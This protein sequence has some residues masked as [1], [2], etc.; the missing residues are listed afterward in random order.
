MSMRFLAAVSIWIGF[1]CVAGVLGQNEPGPLPELVPGSVRVATLNSSLFRPRSNELSLELEGGSSTH[2]KSIAAMVQRVRPD[3]L[4]INE[5]D[6]EPGGNNATKLNSLYFGIGQ[7]GEKAIVFPH[8]YSAEVNTGCPTGN[9]LDGDGKKDGPG[10]CFGYGTHPGQY[11][12]AVFSRFPIE[13]NQIRTFQKFI[14]NDMPMALLPFKPGSS[15]PYYAPDVWK[16]FRLS[17]KSHWDVP[18]QVGWGTLHFLVSHPTP[19]VFD[20]PEDRNGRR[21]HNEIRFFADYIDPSRA[22]YHYDDAGERGGLAAGALFVVAGDLNA[23]PLDGQSYAGAVDQLL[24]HPLVGHE[25]VPRSQGAEIAARNTAAANKDHRGD[26]ATDT[27]DFP[28][29]GVGNLRCDYCLPSRGLH[30]LASGV[31]WPNPGTAEA[32]WTTVTDHHL[33]WIDIVLPTPSR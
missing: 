1:G 22:T 33:V 29:D 11:G 4:L 5:L 31:F 15:E 28:D 32:E 25:P 26:P 27:G 10:D 20:G 9:D 18:I 2:A 13:E 6:Y 14:W 23:D 8:V 30:T 21:N 16:S 3:I 17:S 19:P 7:H 24:H 12:M